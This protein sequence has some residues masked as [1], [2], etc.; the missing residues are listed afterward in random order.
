VLGGFYTL[1]DFD[2]GWQLA[3]GRWVAQH[4]QIPSID[5]FSYTAQGQPWIYPVGSG[6]L[7]YLTYWIGKYALLSYLGAAACV[8]TTA[9]VL[10]RG[11]MVS[12][13]LVILAIPLIADRTTPR[14][15]MFTVVLFAAFLTLLWQQHETGRAALWILPLLMI[16]WV[17][18]H[19]GFVAGLAL[20]GAY[21]LV[22]LLEMVWPERRPM[23]AARVRRSWPWLVTTIGATLLN[24]WGWGIY[25]ALLRQQSVMGSHSETIIEWR[26]AFLNWSRVSTGLSL[27][28]PDAFVIMV[29]GQRNGHSHGA[30]E[31]GRRRST[32]GNTQSIS[33]QIRVSRC[34][35]WDTLSWTITIPSELYRHSIRRCPA[36]HGNQEVP[37]ARSWPALRT[38]VRWPGVR[39]VI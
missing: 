2:L 29:F 8:G 25:R 38:A 27:S 10:R 14:A 15:D 17:N 20:L 26:S 1:T 12:A 9:L 35:H 24:P 19:L 4:H 23:A 6:L 32:H 13:F 16:A 33:P 11:T 37:T 21:V 3:T 5:V 18:L 36:C 22:E 7:F 34:S 30:K 39:W 31:G 28:N